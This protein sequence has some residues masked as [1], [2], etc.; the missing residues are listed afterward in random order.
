MKSIVW[1][2]TFQQNMPANGVFS[3]QVDRR[4][5]LL[6]FVSV[7]DDGQMVATDS[8]LTEPVDGMWLTLDCI[9]SVRVISLYAGG[10]GA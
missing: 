6:A 5:C 4:M 7:C 10:I 1:Q 8:D 3:S 9:D 2:Y